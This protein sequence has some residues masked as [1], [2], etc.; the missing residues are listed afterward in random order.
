MLVEPL[1]KS[2]LRPDEVELLVLDLVLFTAGVL[3]VKVDPPTEAH[4]ETAYEHGVDLL[5]AGAL[6]VS[7]QHR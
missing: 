6:A 5:L 1:L 4:T 2:G 3:L 7:S